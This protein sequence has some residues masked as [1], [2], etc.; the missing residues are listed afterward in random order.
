MRAEQEKMRSDGVALIKR[1]D[2]GWTN[3]TP[4]AP[5][6]DASRLLLDVAAT[7]PQLRRGRFK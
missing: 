3:T 5:Y 1:S 6:K 2:G 7:P 4:S